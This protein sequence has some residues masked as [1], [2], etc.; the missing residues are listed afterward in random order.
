MLAA[1]AQRLEW[2]A[3]APGWWGPGW[4]PIL[5]DPS[6]NKIAVDLDGQYTGVPAQ[7]I[8]FWH[9]SE[10][11]DI[12]AYDLE[13]MLEILASIYDF[14]RDRD[15]RVRAR[16]R[17]SMGLEDGRAPPHRHPGPGVPRDAAARPLSGARLT[18]RRSP[19]LTRT[20]RAEKPRAG[21]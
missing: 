18:G 12:V 15:R 5:E 21:N 16:R 8:G 14:G 11:R 4:L 13:S 3:D 19:A 2:W 17:Q 10:D 7:M 6:N 9:D 1:R 20:A